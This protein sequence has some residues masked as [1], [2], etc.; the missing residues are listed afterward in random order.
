MTSQSSRATQHLLPHLWGQRT[1]A[2]LPTGFGAPRP[3]HQGANIPAT[4]RPH[5]PTEYQGDTGSFATTMRYRDEVAAHGGSSNPTVHRDNEYRPAE[6]PHYKEGCRNNHHCE[7]H[8]RD[9]DG[10]RDGH[11]RKEHR[12]D[13]RDNF[14]RSLGSHERWDNDESDW[15]ASEDKNTDEKWHNLKKFRTRE[16]THLLNV[17]DMP[18]P[19]N[20]GP[21]A[22]LCFDT[23]EHICNLNQWMTAG[24]PRHALN[25]S[26]SQSSSQP[27]LVPDVATG[28]N[29]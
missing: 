13:L 12:R 28:H 8:Q 11:R 3:A 25:G 23:V 17:R 4:Q 14:A 6:T 9:E 24:S 27:T 2:F 20:A 21:F 10:R 1:T 19:D 29:T 16:E 5:G 7:D 22:R 26:T 18:Q 15:G